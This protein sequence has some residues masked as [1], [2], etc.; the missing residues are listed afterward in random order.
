MPIGT[1]KLHSP[2]IQRR[3]VYVERDTG[4]SQNA[5]HNP[6]KEVGQG[7]QGDVQV[8]VS[9]PVTKP[10]K[11]FLVPTKGGTREEGRRR[12][13]KRDT[14]RGRDGDVAD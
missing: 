13:S 10:N 4:S 11:I 3:S 1:L 2:G 12:R 7:V 9:T 14:R 5:G 6:Q 8:H